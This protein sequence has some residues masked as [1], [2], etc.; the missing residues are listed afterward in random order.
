MGAHDVTGNPRFLNPNANLASWD[1]SLG[2]VGTAAHAISQL[3]AH[4]AGY[5]VASLLAFVRQGFTPI[6]PA[7]KGNGY[8]GADIGAVS[9]IPACGHF[10][11]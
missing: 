1:K 10:A 9:V 11:M 7:L 8:N 2:G 3:S 5:T 6:N 4:A